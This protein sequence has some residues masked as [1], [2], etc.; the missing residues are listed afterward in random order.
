MR[1]RRRAFTVLE[2]IIGIILIA[3]MS[4][5]VIPAL[6]G[7]IRDAQTSA[8]AQTLAALSA[9]IFEYRKAVTSYP[10]Q[11]IHLA[12]RPLDTSQDACNAAIGAANAANWRGPYISRELVAGGINIGDATISNTLRRVPVVG[13]PA[14]VT[15]FIDVVGADSLSVL[16]IEAQFDGLPLTVAS[17]TTGTIRYTK[18]AIGAIPAA[19]THTYNMSYGI[20]I[21]GC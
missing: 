6:M 16:D 1:A 17:P 4:A 13:P 7:R 18:A 19:P 5:A 11:L 3:A 20:P 8:T 9:A 12:Q 2:V 21:T 15:L 14:S 10:Q